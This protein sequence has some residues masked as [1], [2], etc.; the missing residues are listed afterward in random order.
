MNL[1][2]LQI[3]SGYCVRVSFRMLEICLATIGVCDFD[4]LTSVGAFF[5]FRKVAKLDN[6]KISNGEVAD[7]IINL[8]ENLGICDSH[9]AKGFKLSKKKDILKSNKE[10]SF[11]KLTTEIEKRQLKK[12]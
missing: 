5:I 2:K 10:Y 9:T 12:D 8:N 1:E 4:A 11:A 3:P 6:K 7:A